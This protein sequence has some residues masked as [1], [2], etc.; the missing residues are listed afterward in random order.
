MALNFPSSPTEGQ[1]F[2]SGSVVYTFLG[3]VWNA[4]PLDTALPFNYVVNPAMQI[5][6]QNGNTGS[7]VAGYYPADQWISSTN[8]GA[9]VSASRL[10]LTTPNGSVNRI[11]L[12]VASDGALTAGQYGHYLQLIEGLRVAELG[13]GTLSAKQVVMRFGW[14]SPAGTY[15]VFIRSSNSGHSYVS[16]FTVSAGQANTDTE[17]II[18]IPPITTGTWNK[19]TTTGMNFGFCIGAGTT[20]QGVNNTWNTGNFLGTAANTNGLAANGTFNFFDVGLYLDPLNTGRAPPWEVLSE[21]QAMFECQRYWQKQATA[22]GLAYAA[23]NTPNRSAYPNQAPMRTAPAASLVGTQRGWDQ[24]T[25]PNLTSI[26]VNY[27][28]TWYFENNYNSAS[29]QTTGRAAML[30]DSNMTSIYTAQSARM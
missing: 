16:N 23:T 9:G 2:I 19:D 25:A 3:G 11:R 15:S 13:W 12:V 29:A 5:S 18:V 30:I 17:H 20:Y 8:A 10:Q 1:K 28:N 22:I 24:A 4:A 21:R 6:Q 26:A 27:S 7:S 14:R